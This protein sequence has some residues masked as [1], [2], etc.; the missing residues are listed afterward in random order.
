[1]NVA[2]KEKSERH[3]D[4]QIRPAAI[5]MSAG[6]AVIPPAPRFITLPCLV[7]RQRTEVSL[8]KWPRGWRMILIVGGAAAAWLA[9][10]GLIRLI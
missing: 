4:S 6:K 9:I 3:L 10:V 5:D 1:M 8:E 7:A 2:V